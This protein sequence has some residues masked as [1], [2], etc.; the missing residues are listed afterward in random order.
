MGYNIAAYTERY[1]SLTTCNVYLV[2]SSSKTVNSEKKLI[3]QQKL[4][5]LQKQKWSSFGTQD[6]L[7]QMAY[8]N[9]RK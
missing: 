9:S 6:K 1:N 8:E 7:S 3:G 4:N 5:I 2:F